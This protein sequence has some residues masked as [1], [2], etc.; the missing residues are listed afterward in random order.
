MQNDKESDR[1]GYYGM[2]YLERGVKVIGDEGVRA[3]GGGGWG[4]GGGEG[5][6][7]GRGEG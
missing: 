1:G 5:G 6:R 3:V 7:G 2:A 4:E